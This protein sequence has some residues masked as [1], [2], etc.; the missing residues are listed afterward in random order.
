MILL[1]VAPYL[2]QFNNGFYC[3]AGYAALVGS[4]YLG[5]KKDIAH[6]EAASPS[7]VILGMT[8]LW[9]G[10]FGFNA[11]SAYGA[12]S[13]AALAFSNTNICAAAAMLAWMLMD[14]IYGKPISAIGAAAGAISGLVVITPACG[15]VTPGAAMIMGI[16]G[17]M[18]C[19]TAS[20]FYKKQQKLEDP[21]D[22]FPVH[23]VGGTSKLI[24]GPDVQFACQH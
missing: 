21:V 2:L 9:V 19:H 24:A 22:V 18:G 13:S 7:Y 16:L 15:F 17:G 23:G 3:F 11:G 4:W 14:G 6:G 12:N 10:W 5:P 8:F 20:H 1:L